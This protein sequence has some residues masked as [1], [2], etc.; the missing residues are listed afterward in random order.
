MWN[1]L[2]DLP[3][4]KT[5]DAIEQATNFAHKVWGGR[6]HPHVFIYG[7][8]WKAPPAAQATLGSSFHSALVL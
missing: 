3:S 4:E 8:V 6:L 5:Q 2:K 1:N 7:S